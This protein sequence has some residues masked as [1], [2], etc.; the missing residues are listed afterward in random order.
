VPAARLCAW[1]SGCKSP[2]VVSKQA[3]RQAAPAPHPG[4]PCDPASH[5]HHRAAP[6]GRIWDCRTGRSI[7]TMQGHVKQCLAIDF[8]PNGYHVATG[9]DDHTC[10]VWD[11]RKKGCLYTIPAHK[12]LLSTVR[13][14]PSSGH[15]LLTSSYDALAKVRAEVATGVVS[16]VG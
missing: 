11:L 9:S 8:S 2:E 14:E 7:L 13:Y 12:S 6:A 1:F 10:R 3:R 4:I 15:Y 5:P 16:D